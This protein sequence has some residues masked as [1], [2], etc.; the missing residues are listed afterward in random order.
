ME[1][2]LGYSRTSETYTYVY[3]AGTRMYMIRMYKT[4]LENI[5]VHR[6]DLVLLDVDDGKSMMFREHIYVLH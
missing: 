4:A 2:D 6:Q 1:T 3:G 5:G